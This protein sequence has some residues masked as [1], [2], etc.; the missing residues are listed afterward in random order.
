MPELP[1]HPGASPCLRCG[2]CCKNSP[3]PFGKHT[4]DGC[5]YLVGDGPGGYSCEIADFIMRASGWEVSPAFG[6]GCCRTLFNPVRD[7]LIGGSVG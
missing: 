6:A 4:P 1:L 3:C 2:E 7:Q 5:V